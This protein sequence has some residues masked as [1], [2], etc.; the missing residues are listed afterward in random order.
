MRN[1]IY[2][3]HQAFNN[4]FS[5]D[6][7]V[8]SGKREYNHYEEALRYHPDPLKMKD[9][10]NYRAYLIWF[11][12]LYGIGQVLINTYQDINK[13][14]NKE[15]ANIFTGKKGLNLTLQDLARY[16]YDLV[17]FRSD[18]TEYQRCLLATDIY[19]KHSY[20][21]AISEQLYFL[22]NVESKA[23]ATIERKLTGIDNARMQLIGVTI[24]LG[25]FVTSYLALK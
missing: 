17:D 18:A 15:K 10:E 6:T 4:I 1:K 22:D 2:N 24:S 21:A 25:A 20:S 8:L 13:K 5:Y 3:R 12:E 9:I 23:I 16:N 11:N 7:D 19:E 14:A